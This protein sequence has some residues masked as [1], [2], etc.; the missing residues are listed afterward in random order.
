YA[1]VSGTCVAT[2]GG[3][4]GTCSSGDSRPCGSDVGECRKGT[5]RCVSGS[6]G[7]CEGELGPTAEKC[8]GKDDNCDGTVDNAVIDATACEKVLGVCAGSKRACIDGGLETPCAGASY[9]ASYQ[10]VELSC[11]GLDNDC[12]GTADNSGVSGG[13]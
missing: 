7:P 4:A 8:N 13:A 2:G 12:D 3:D 11:D 5:Q 1:C 6:F 10:P 9:G